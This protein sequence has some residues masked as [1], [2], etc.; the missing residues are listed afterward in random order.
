MCH[1]YRAK[2]NHPKEQKCL[3]YLQSPFMNTLQI[4]N[5]SQIYEC[6]QSIEHWFH[7]VIRVHWSIEF[8]FRPQ[9]VRRKF[10]QDGLIF[11]TPPYA[12]FGAR[13]RCFYCTLLPPP[14][15]AVASS[16]TSF[17]LQ[18]RPKSSYFYTNGWM[19]CSVRWRTTHVFSLL[20][21]AVVF[22]IWEVEFSRP[23]IGG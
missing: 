8:K 23:W 19:P 4:I 13:N 3:V 14:Q 15:V 12:D 21:L 9:K 5:L 7:T 2:Y 22:A 16:R 11:T 18:G 1:S 17:L 6:P 20:Y 10:Q